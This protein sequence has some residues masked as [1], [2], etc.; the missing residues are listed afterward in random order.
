MNAI[1][2]TNISIRKTKADR[3]EDGTPWMDLFKNVSVYKLWPEAFIQNS[4]TKRAGTTYHFLSP[5]T[6]T[7]DIIFMAGVADT[8]RNFN[9]PKAKKRKKQLT[10]SQPKTLQN[11]IC[12]RQTSRNGSL[13]LWHPSPFSGIASPEN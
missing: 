2:K 5:R 10:F 11:L 9:A 12:S 3:Y 13:K 8:K 6:R 4:R 1:T 7:C